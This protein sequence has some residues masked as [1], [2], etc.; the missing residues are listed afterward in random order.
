[1]FDAGRLQP[2]DTLL[3]HGGGSGIGTLAIQ[4]AVAHGARVITTARV[5]KHP[6]L[7]ALGAEITVDYRSEDFVAVTRHATGNA[8]ADVI[9]DIMGASYLDRNVEALALG[10]RLVVIGLQGGRRAELNLGT[11]L[12]KRGTIFATT[13]RSRPVDQK[14]AI[15]GAVRDH[16]WPM[17]AAKL[18]RP[19]VHARLSMTD[20]A[21]AH[22]ILD[23]S[24]HV[25]KVLL[26][27]EGGPS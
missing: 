27:A 7:R 22:E 18:V 25:G 1:V 10:G 24:S 13:L 2:L 14:A 5:D 11:L 8:G 16:V 4:L 21:E 26:V 19:V 17:V 12:A 15:V 9:L 3:V 6:A 20:A 23:A